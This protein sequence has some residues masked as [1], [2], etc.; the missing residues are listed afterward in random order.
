MMSEK[1]P[2][3]L[4]LFSDTGGGHRSAAEATIEALHLE[5]GERL[6]TQMVD[7][8]KEIA[9]TP[10]N[11]L[12]DWY[13]YMVRAPKVW[14]LGYQLS[15]GRRRASLITNSAWPYVRSALR[16]VAE[17]YPSDLIVSFHPLANAP[18]LRALG[19]NRPPYV[20]VVTD[21]VTVHSLWYSRKVDLTLVPTEEARRRALK[22][23][24]QAGQVQV[25]GLPVAERFCQPAGDRSMLRQRLGWPQ[26]CPVVILVGG[27][28]GMGPL[29]QT[30]LAIADAHLPIA[31]G[32]IAGRNQELKARLEARSW[33]MPTFVYGF[34][35]EMPDFMRAADIL[36]TKA[37][38]G[39][40]TEAMN[41]GL[42]MILYSRLPGQEDGNVAFVRAKRVGVWAPKPEQIIST[43]SDWIEHPE[44]REAA[45]AACHKIA[46]PQ[47]ARQIAHI[48]AAKA[49]LEE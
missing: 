33:P 20:V 47:A 38:P 43:L 18:F 24:L 29:E 13:P 27:G 10:L 46:K 45:A 37:G 9:P 35:R 19:A 7:I 44:K 14:G 5:Y 31:L 41:A 16:K 28:E 32:V 17:A 22:N 25:V 4:I 40:I 42:P 11:M 12:P 48:L 39:T 2:H 30:A 1:K 23:K 21:L 36:V 49:G 26:D 8:F 15:D 3:I 34:V 6:T